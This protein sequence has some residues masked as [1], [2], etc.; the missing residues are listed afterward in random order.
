M[1]LFS[2]K[3]QP[4][5]AE[6]VKILV[7]A[8]DVDVAAIARGFGEGDANVLCALVIMVPPG[9]QGRGLSRLGVK[10]M[11]DIARAHGLGALVAPVRPSWKLRYGIED[12]LRE[13]HEQNLER[14]TVSAA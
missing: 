10:A 9:L 14:W 11:S 6:V 12:I 8:G 3:I 7:S 13:M 2:G 5:A 1:R 4:I